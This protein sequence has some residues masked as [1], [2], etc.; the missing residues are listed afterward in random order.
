MMIIPTSLL[1]TLA[2]C[3]VFF[4]TLLYLVFFKPEYRERIIKSAQSPLAPWTKKEGGAEI[5]IFMMVV[6]FFVFS[7][8]LIFFLCSLL[9]GAATLVSG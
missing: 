6:L 7:C 1:I 5:L 2:F 4:A 9:F 3:A 8:M